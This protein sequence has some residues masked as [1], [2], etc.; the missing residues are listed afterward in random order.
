MHKQAQL[1]AT[2]VVGVVI[3]LAVAMAS[4]RPTAQQ[5]IPQGD[6]SVATLVQSC[7]QQ[8]L[9]Q[10]VIDYGAEPRWCYKDGVLAHFDDAYTRVSDLVRSNLQSCI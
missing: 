8:S 6:D 3:I 10:A 5:V 9:E 1:A 7:L 4:N 2:L